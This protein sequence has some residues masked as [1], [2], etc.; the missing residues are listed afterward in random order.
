VTLPAGSFAQSFATWIAAV[1]NMDYTVTPAT[2]EL[3]LNN[4]AVIGGSVLN[5]WT[6][7]FAL[8]DTLQGSWIN[9]QIPWRAMIQLRGI[10]TWII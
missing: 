7:D 5:G 3:R 10:G 8:F 9:A 1:V 6:L 4:Y 2:Y